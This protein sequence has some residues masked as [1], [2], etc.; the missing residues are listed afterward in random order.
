MEK[1]PFPL[2]QVDIR[3]EPEKATELKYLAEQQLKS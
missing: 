3:P 2:I 1:R